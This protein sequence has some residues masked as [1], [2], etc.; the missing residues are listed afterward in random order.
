MCVLARGTIV[1]EV[2]S[3]GGTRLRC[4][5]ACLQPL[6]IVL[7]VLCSGAFFAGCCQGSPEPYSL[8]WHGF[9][10]SAVVVRYHGVACDAR[11]RLRRPRQSAGRSLIQ[12]YGCACGYV[13]AARR[14]D[15]CMLA[16]RVGRR[17]DGRGSRSHAWGGRM[18]SLS[19]MWVATAGAHV[20][21]L[22]LPKFRQTC[23]N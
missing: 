2:S 16:V 14:Y 12:L 4:P 18:P 19:C 10:G 11:S 6:L 22:Y 3:L 7:R 17:R 1:Q 21:T 23:A 13:Y 8:V 20:D 15:A 5:H 9:F